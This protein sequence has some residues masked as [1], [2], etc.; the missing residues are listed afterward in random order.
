MPYDFRGPLLKLDRA[1]HHFVDLEGSEREFFQKNAVSIV[2]EDKPKGDGKFV[3]IRLDPPP[4]EIMHVIAG[5]II[6]HLRSTLDQIAVAFARLSLAKPNSSKVHF[7]T[8]ENLPDFEGHC[9]I[10]LAGFDQ[11]LADQ[12]IGTKAYDG[13]CDTLRAVFRMANIDKHFELIPA[14]ASGRLMGLEGFTIANA[15]TGLI[16]GGAIQ[17]LK[18][19]I[20][21]SDL[22]PRGI[23]MPNKPKAQIHVAGC[24][25][26]GE[27][28]IYN[29]K[30]LIPFL[31]S[32]IDKTTQVCASLREHCIKTGRTPAA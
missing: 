24:V 3:K 31:R 25:T 18:D 5:E 9:K 17:S 22:G 29:G 11:D 4:P 15:K 23:F 2:I 20:V 10:Y 19:G 30:P 14:G 12:I 16:I 28:A 13:G 21:I 26:L 1:N 7:P 27:A 32:M 8:G 6:Y